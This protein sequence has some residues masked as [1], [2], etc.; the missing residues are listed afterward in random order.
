[1][2]VDDEAVIRSVMAEY[3]ELHGY[4]VD[5]FADCEAAHAAFDACRHGV[6]ITDL[7][8]PAGDGCDGFR[9]VEELMRLEPE[10]ACIVMTATGGA[11]CERRARNAGAVAFLEKPMRLAEVATL[12]GR[13]LDPGLSRAV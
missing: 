5:S 7:R 10:V 13:L 12:V 2:V 1:M 6:V 8:F 4:D 3:L 9:L 11:D